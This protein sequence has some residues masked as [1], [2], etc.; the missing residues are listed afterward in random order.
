MREPRLTRKGAVDTGVNRAHGCEH[1]RSRKGSQRGQMRRAVLLGGGQRWGERVRLALPRAENEQ[2]ENRVRDLAENELHASRKLLRILLHALRDALQ[3][4]EV[5]LLPGSRV[6]PHEHEPPLKRVPS[7]SPRGKWRD[8][9]ARNEPASV[10]LH[11]RDDLCLRNLQINI[12][13]HDQL[14]DLAEEYTIPQRDLQG[15]EL[16]RQL[17]HHDHEQAQPRGY[18]RSRAIEKL[19]KHGASVSCSVGLLG[20]FQ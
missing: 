9:D 11:Q 8:H 10:L 7:D 1:G 14:L 17:A 6:C 4:A 16:T 2:R 13:L 5:C 20:S 15:D 12:T 19:L 18:A 3:I